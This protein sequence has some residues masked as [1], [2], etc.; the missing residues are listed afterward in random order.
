MLCVGI[1]KIKRKEKYLCHLCNQNSNHDE[2]SN[3]SSS[4]S[5]LKTILAN[6]QRKNSDISTP[7]MSISNNNNNNQ[8]TTGLLASEL[9]DTTN[10]LND[11]VKLEISMENAS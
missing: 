9:N 2:S 7:D 5:S 3:S 4:S 1:T 6:Q 10:K 8:N 11:S